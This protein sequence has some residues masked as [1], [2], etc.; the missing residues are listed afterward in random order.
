MKNWKNQIETLK[1]K[2]QSKNVPETAQFFTMF[3]L[4][5]IAFVPPRKSY[6]IWLLFTHKNEAISVTKRSWLRRSISLTYQIGVHTIALEKAFF[7]KYHNTLFCLFKILHKH[8]FQFLLGLTIAP[9]EIE[10]FMLMQNFG[11]T[12]KSIM[13][14]FE[15]TYWVTETAKHKKK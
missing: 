11:G 15:K 1:N 10:T 2:Q 14:F 12:T 9:R 13:V 6:R 3:S 8:C 7:Q 4:S 5:R